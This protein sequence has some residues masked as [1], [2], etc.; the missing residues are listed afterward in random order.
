MEEGAIVF[1]I[2]ASIAGGLSLLVAVAIFIAVRTR[3]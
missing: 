3:A 1:L 2:S